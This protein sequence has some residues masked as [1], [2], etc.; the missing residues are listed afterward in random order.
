ML[1]SM[2][3]YSNFS[4]NIT[5]RGNGNPRVQLYYRL[6]I[7][8]T[9]HR[10]SADEISFFSIM[11]KIGLY[12]G[13][14]VL[15][16]TRVSDDKKY[17]SFIVT[18]S[19]KNSISKLIEYLKKFPLVS[20]KRLDFQSWCKVLDLQR[21]NSITTSYIDKALDI[22]KDFNNTRTTYNWDHLPNSYLE[23]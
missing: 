8:Q 12:L 13:S 17:F 19:S 5:K 10:L 7:R 4:I 2:V 3:L 9:Y 22:R 15:S 11:E 14:N 20:S 23:K 18:A 16:R 21:E 6:E 1:R